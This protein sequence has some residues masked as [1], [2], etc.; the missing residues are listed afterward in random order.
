MWKQKL[1]LGTSDQY[2]ISVEEQIRLFCRTG[3]EGFFTD[4]SC[5][6]NISTYRRLAD[7]LGMIYQSVHAP[8]DKAA[9]M[10]SGTAAERD[11]AIAE[12]CECVAACAQNG[13]PIMIIHP[14]IGFDEHEP[15]ETGAESYERVIRFA[16]DKGVQLAVENV[17]Q[18]RHLEYL[19]EKFLKYENVGFC[20]DSG[21]EMCYNRGRDMLAVY[22]KR[23]IA[24]HLNDNLGIR[25]CGGGITWTDDLHLLPYDG[26]IDWSY[27]AE[28]LAEC[29]YDGI[30]TF[31]LNTLSKP[32]RHEN[33]KYSKMPIEEYIS[34]AYI[35]AC[36]FAAELGRIKK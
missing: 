20:W 2:G 27:A 34:E 6:E 18:E 17:E 7:E 5:N 15:N 23:L 28:R 25:D 11:A 24:T 22:G 9:V 21:H 4:W 26:I 31:E 3:F 30:L 32:E 10:W 16:A 8:F 36:R 29:G 1:C 19:F 35:R 13:V 12:L 14:Y 33:D